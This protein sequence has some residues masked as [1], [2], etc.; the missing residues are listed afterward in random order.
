MLL[1]VK[2][3]SLSR[4]YSRQLVGVCSKIGWKTWLTKTPV[5]K[6]TAIALVLLAGG[7]VLTYRYLSK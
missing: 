2:D 6:T 7:S 1:S 4:D 3:P 5:G